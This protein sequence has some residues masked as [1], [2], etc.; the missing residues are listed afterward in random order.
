M[1]KALGATVRELRELQ[2]A[3]ALTMLAAYAGRPTDALPGVARKL[4]ASAANFPLAVAMAGAMLQDRPDEQWPTLLEQLKEADLGYLEAALLQYRQHRSMLA[5]I[6]VSVQE[7]PKDVR[8]RY[9]DFAV[10]PEDAAVPER[11][12]QM[13]WCAA[14]VK[15]AAAQRTVN[16][17]VDRSLVRRDGKGHL[18]LHDLQHD[19]MRAKAGELAPRH[20]RLVEAYRSASPGKALHAV[21]GDEYLFEHIARH[22]HDGEGAPALRDL[23]LD[24]RWAGGQVEGHGRER[25]PRGLRVARPRVGR[26]HMQTVR[27]RPSARTHNPSTRGEFARQ[28]EGQYRTLEI[29]DLFAAAAEIG[30]DPLAGHVLAEDNLDYT[31]DGPFDAAPAADDGDEPA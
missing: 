5:V 3:D 22:V 1:A 23:L 7:L 12:P 11:V 10:F 30:R 18:T 14:G 15:L 21:A 19:Y 31:T 27:P 25:P 2:P 20:A 6:E 17:L 29:A 13:L 24:H 26:T 16:K 8:L 28:R 4:S 9:L